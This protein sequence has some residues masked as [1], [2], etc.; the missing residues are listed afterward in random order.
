M[1]TSDIA[2]CKNFTPFS[3]TPGTHFKERAEPPQ[4]VADTRAGIAV[5]VDEAPNRRF[6]LGEVSG[7]EDFEA[8]APATATT[9]EPMNSSRWARP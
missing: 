1:S 8:I 6:M 9:W 4:A 3:R 5:V 7:K 2:Y